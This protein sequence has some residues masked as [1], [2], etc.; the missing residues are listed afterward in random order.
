MGGGGGGDGDDGGCGGGSD[1][2]VIPKF[3]TSQPNGHICASRQC[4][5]TVLWF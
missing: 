2:R 1:G 5:G 4:C 3:T